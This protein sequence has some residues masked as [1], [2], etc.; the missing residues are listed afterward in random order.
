M[1]RS[2][3]IF[4]CFFIIFSFITY[5][6]TYKRI[7]TGIPFKD[8]VTRKCAANM[9]ISSIESKLY[10]QTVIKFHGIYGLPNIKFN[11]MAS[12]LLPCI[13]YYPMFYNNHMKKTLGYVLPEYSKKYIYINNDHWKKIS[14][15]SKSR[16]LIHECTHLTLGTDDYAYIGDEKY[17]NLRGKRARTNADTI[18]H[19][20]FDLNEYKC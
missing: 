11:H 2:D 6:F 8:S 9:V 12:K 13:N 19:I 5:E 1:D 17:W 18:T 4:L 14:I 10:T 3:T 16:V 7:G 15:E 20:I